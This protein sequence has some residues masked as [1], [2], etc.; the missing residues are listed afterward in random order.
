MEALR[1]ALERKLRLHLRP[2]AVHE[3]EPDAH[4]RQQRQVVHQ[5]G[6]GAG[7]DQSAGEGDDEGL[8]AVRVHVRRD[9]AQ[10]GDE[11]CVVVDHFGGHLGRGSGVVHRQKYTDRLALASERGFLPPSLKM[12]TPR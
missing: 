2:R 5:A 11:A 7:L 9:L 12:T 4:R 3:H 1:H 8:A 6:Q 10:P